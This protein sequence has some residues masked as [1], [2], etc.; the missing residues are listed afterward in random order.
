MFF[1][2]TLTIPSGTTAADPA[3]QVMILTSGLVILVD[4]F[5]VPD[6]AGLVGVRIK[7]REHVAW[8][9]NTDTWIVRNESGPRWEEDYDLSVAPHELILEGYNEDDTYEHDVIF[10]FAVKTKE[11]VLTEIWKDVLR[12]RL[13]GGGGR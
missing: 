8:P 2:D 7:H 10:G 3:R 5:F 1:E 13:P 11:N 12:P 4:I 9:T 6:C